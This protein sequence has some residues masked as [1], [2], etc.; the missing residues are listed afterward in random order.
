MNVVKLIFKGGIGAIF[1]LLFLALFSS[2]DS[3]DGVIYELQKED[4]KE[5]FLASNQIEVPFVGVEPVLPAWRTVVIT[6]HQDFSVALGE[7]RLP[8][9]DFEKEMLVLYTYT[10]TYRREIRIKSISTSGDALKIS[11]EI[12]DGTPGTGDACQPYQRFV[13]VRLPKTDRPKVEVS[14]RE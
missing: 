5:E 13:A 2:C 12:E 11:L 8:E 1:L 6:N 4:L 7:N 10:S 9:P 14:L 3:P